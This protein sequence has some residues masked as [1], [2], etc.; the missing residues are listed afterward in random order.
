MYSNAYIFRYSAIMVII[1][2]ALLSTAAM[3]LKPFQERNVAIDKM[4]GILASAQIPDVNTSNAIKLFN[5]YVK[6]EI[7]INQDGDVVEAY[8]VGNMEDGKAFK[9]DMKKELYKKSKG[10]PFELPLYVIE[11]NGTKLF[12]IPVRGVGLW[13]PLW[14]NIALNEDL[15]TIVGVTFDHKGETPG[16]GAEI[17]TDFF[18]DKFVGKK[19]FDDNNQF[20]SISV[21][22]G[23]IDKL[24]KE[25]KDFA[26]DAIS[27]GTITCNG[28]NDMLEDVLESYL[29]YLQKNR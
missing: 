17:T 6:E 29:P 26:V 9:I 2:A 5:E 13:G 18:T 14:G 21:V 4:G 20:K 7:V 1:A 10:E 8:K 24:P 22:K 16:L 3:L 27:G 12:I 28:V 19:I 11:K 23:G 25:L 15:N